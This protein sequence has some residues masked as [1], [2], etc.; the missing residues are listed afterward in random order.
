MTKPPFD[1]SEMMKT[2]NP[3]ALTKMFDP[4]AMMKSL[5]DAGKDMPDMTAFMESN[6]RNFEAMTE[7]NKAAA[8]TYKD[9][10]EKQMQLFQ[11]VTEPAQQKLKEA[12]DPAT[13]K[14]GTDAM[15]EAV[16]QALAL[17]QSM[18]DAARAANEKA[19]EAVKDQ[20][21]NVTR[22]MKP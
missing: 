20:A 18:A 2:F 16:E 17:M 10:L 15:N 5:Q 9:M 3:E 14:A 7:A 11:S 13:I 21:A 1:F 22:S 6:Q 19:F 12:A 8:A 4:A